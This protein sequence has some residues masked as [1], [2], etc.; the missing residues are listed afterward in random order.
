MVTCGISFLPTWIRL[1][2]PDPRS[3]A[4]T[5]IRQNEELKRKHNIVNRNL[6]DCGCFD[7]YPLKRINEEF[8]ENKKSKGKAWGWKWYDAR[9]IIA[10]A[11]GAPD[12]E[13]DSWTHS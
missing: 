12:P 2:S 7:L 3:D 10:I 5:V 8:S 1:I 4:D 6:V 9:Y 11:L 13:W